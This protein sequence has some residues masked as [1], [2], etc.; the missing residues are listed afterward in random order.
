MDEAKADGYDTNATTIIA[1][2]DSVAE[3]HEMACAREHDAYPLPWEVWRVVLVEPQSTYLHRGAHGVPRHGAGERGQVQGL[4]ENG[5]QRGGGKCHV[6][7]RLGTPA[8]GSPLSVWPLAGSAR[9]VARPSV[10]QERR[11]LQELVSVCS[12]HI[13]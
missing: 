4:A 6:G 3:I 5:D 7:E 11:P 10:H 12:L 9:Q 1:D 2:I 13:V 8:P